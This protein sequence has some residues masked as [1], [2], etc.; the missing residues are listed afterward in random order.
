MWA[1]LQIDEV[2]QKGFTKTP[3][4][5]FKG[6]KNLRDILSGNTIVSDK[7]K[8]QI[9]HRNGTCSPYYNRKNTMCY[10]QIANTLWFTNHKNKKSFTV[11]R[12]LSCKSEYPTYLMKCTLYKI[13]YVGK[14]GTP[15]NI[16]LNNHR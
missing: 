3:I 9:I 2:I 11:C 1:I 10:K 4:V 13:Q 8:K 12:K 15:F 5:S 7:V 6:T 14:A 16:R